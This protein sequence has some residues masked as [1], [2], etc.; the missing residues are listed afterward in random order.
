MT[1]V[2]ALVAS[3]REFG[4]VLEAMGAIALER[5]ERITAAR[6]GRT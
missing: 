5:V 2:D 6:L 3:P 4:W 1:V